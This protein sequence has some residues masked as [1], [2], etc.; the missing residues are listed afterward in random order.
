MKYKSNF[1]T[2]TVTKKKSFVTLFFYF[3]LQSP[4][5][6]EMKVLNR[7]HFGDHLDECLLLTSPLRQSARW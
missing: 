5:I 4:R 6:D 2:P 1:S 7:Q 3:H